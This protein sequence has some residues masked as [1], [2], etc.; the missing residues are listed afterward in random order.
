MSLRCRN[1]SIWP[2]L[3]LPN[4][5]CSPSRL[6]C[7]PSSLANWA[8]NHSSLSNGGWSTLPADLLTTF[9][10]F[11]AGAAAA[12]LLP[13]FSPLVF[14]PLALSVFLWLAAR[15]SRLLRLMASWRFRRRRARKHPGARTPWPMRAPSC[16]IP[17]EVRRHSS[18][19]PALW[20]TAGLSRG[21]GGRVYR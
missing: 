14:L 9:F 7:P 12:L 1:S 2:A 4:T 5:A 17:A 19:D 21:T 13:V 16:R 10:L 15:L 18:E 20:R 8:A 6:F 11:F 3:L